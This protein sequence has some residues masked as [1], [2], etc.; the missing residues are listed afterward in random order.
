MAWELNGTHHWLYTNY[1]DNV[2]DKKIC[3]GKENIKALLVAS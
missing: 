3:I 1:D 2:L